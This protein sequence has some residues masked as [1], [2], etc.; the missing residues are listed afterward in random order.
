[1]RFEKEIGERAGSVYTR[2]KVSM[3]L[4]GGSAHKLSNWLA[5]C[6]CESTEAQTP[7]KVRCRRAPR[8]ECPRK[9]GMFGEGSAEMCVRALVVRAPRV[10]SG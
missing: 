4:A 9:S 3:C 1:M 10:V 6:V 8:R 2:G 7:L 5:E